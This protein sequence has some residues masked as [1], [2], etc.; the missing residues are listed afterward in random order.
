MSPSSTLSQEPTNNPSTGSP[1]VGPLPSQQPSPFPSQHPSPVPSQHPLALPSAIPTQNASAVLSSQTTVQGS[2]E[3]IKISEATSNQ[4]GQ[5]NM[6]THMPSPT[7]TAVQSSNVVRVFNSFVVANT[8]GLTSLELLSSPQITV[9]TTAYVEFATEVLANW[10]ANQNLVHPQNRRHLVVLLSQGKILKVMDSPCPQTVSQTT[11][12]QQVFAYT[13]LYISDENP[14]MVYKRFVKTS[15]LAINSGE[16]QLKLA[17]IDPMSSMV[18]LGAPQS[19]T[20][21]AITTIPEA[22]RNRVPMDTKGTMELNEEHNIVTICL[23]LAGA[24]LAAAFLVLVLLVAIKR[25]IVSRE[26]GKLHGQSEGNDHNDDDD[27]DDGMSKISGTSDTSKSSKMSELQSVE[28]NI[29]VL[30]ASTCCTIED[31]THLVVCKAARSADAL[32]AANGGENESISD[33]FQPKTKESVVSNIAGSRRRSTKTN[34]LPPTQRSLRR[35]LFEELAQKLA[36][37]NVGAKRASPTQEKY[38]RGRSIASGT[39]QPNPSLSLAM[40]DASTE[41]N[42]V[43]VNSSITVDSLFEPAASKKDYSHAQPAL[44][45]EHSCPP[46]SSWLDQ[47]PHSTPTIGTILRTETPARHCGIDYV[48]EQANTLDMTRSLGTSVEECLRA[49]NPS[50][51]NQAWPPTAPT[52]RLLEPDAGTINSPIGVDYLSEP[53]VVESGIRTRSS[54]IQNGAQWVQVTH[55]EDLDDSNSKK[56]SD[57][58]SDET[59]EVPKTSWTQ[60]GSQ[61]VQLWGEHNDHH[62]SRMEKSKSDPDSG[63]VYSQRDVVVGERMGCAFYNDQTNNAGYGDSEHN[64]ESYITQHEGSPYGQCPG[65]SFW[66]EPPWDAQ[67]D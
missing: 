7:P 15:R 63:G 53:S 66:D 34:C 52:S 21:K 10:T 14:T 58:D 31:E 61:W 67:H 3:N 65:H 41:S 40:H 44:S 35:Q 51:V 62:P 19:Q 6:S 1:S 48:W 46:I 26:K 56:S 33:K 60:R 55:A 38:V 50:Q 54:W 39:G 8:I 28:S 30:E 20:E 49:L 64:E 13:D 43:T 45:R 59:E 24:I 25:R 47:Q 36:V 57:Y 29:S 23:I 32:L 11:L 5:Q 22:Q 2:N 4:T 16:L 9:L 12:C 18:I 17:E 37:R 42:D 27:D